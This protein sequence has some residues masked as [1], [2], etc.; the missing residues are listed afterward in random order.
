MINTAIVEAMVSCRV[1]QETFLASALTSRKYWSGP[2]DIFKPFYVFVFP[3]QL[4]SPG[5]FSI[6]KL[7]GN[8]AMNTPMEKEFPVQKTENLP[9][10]SR[11][12]K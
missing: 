1:G 2:V 3:Q 5:G 6:F 9:F 7:E 11:P 4:V 8:A 12:S 10:L